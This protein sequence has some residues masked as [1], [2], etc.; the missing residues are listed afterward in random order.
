MFPPRLELATTRRYVC[1]WFTHPPC[2]AWEIL[3]LWWAASSGLWYPSSFLEKMFAPAKALIP[4][5]LFFPHIKTLGPN[6]SSSLPRV[7][8]HP[9]GETLP[10]FQNP[11]SGISRPGLEFPPPLL[12]QPRLYERISRILGLTGSPALFFGGPTAAR[13]SDQWFWPKM[14]PPPIVR[15]GSNQTCVLP[16]FSLARLMEPGNNKGSFPRESF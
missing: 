4:R 7:R 11:N 6:V 10:G 12:F 15:H 8:T 1:P 16:Q 5:G 13:V 14:G 9:K 3:C 2:C